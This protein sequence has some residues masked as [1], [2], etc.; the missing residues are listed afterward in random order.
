MHGTWPLGRLG[1]VC[2]VTLAMVTGITALRYALPAVPYTVLTNFVTN[3][4]ALSIHAVSA[5]IALLV[6]PCQFLSTLRARRPG[7]HRMLGRIYAGSVLIGWVF[8]IPVGLHA[9][10]GRVASAG[11][12]ALGTCWIIATTAGITYAI[13]GDIV[14]HRRWMFRSYAL[15]CAAITLRLYIAVSIAAGLPLS[16]SYPA[17][18]WL[19]WAPNLVGVE[20]ALRRRPSSAGARTPRPGIAS[21]AKSSRLS[22]GEASS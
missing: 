17:I 22:A 7:L 11:F 2:L 3:R 21:F 10:T 5:A 14:M 18:A 1:W 19:C 12:L 4:V 8:S 16:V 9:E 15:T 20:L 13:R 6:G